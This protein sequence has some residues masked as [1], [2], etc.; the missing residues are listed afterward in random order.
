[1]SA[2]QHGQPGEWAKVRGTVLSLWPLFLSFAALGA[3]AMA[4]VLG[5]VTVLIGARAPMLFGALFL[6][7]LVLTL[8][9]W[10]NGVRSLESFFKGARGEERVASLLASL[11][12]GWHVFHD[13][14]AGPYHVDHVVAGP[15]GVFAVE[16]KNWRGSVVANGGRGDELVVDGH[17]PSRSPTAQ[18][19]AEAEAV[20]AKLAHLGFEVQVVPVVCFASDTLADGI[21][22]IGPVTACN[23]SEVVRWIA[24]AQHVVADDEL[25][26]M[27]Q[28]METAR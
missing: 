16:T 20:K 8:L 24:S 3:F 15:G 2:K 18:A 21:V 19:K 4:F 14:V 25:V 12:D 6:G 22:K 7:S 17:L 5:R 26:R 27:V 10:R 28:L 9:M 23:G 13:F 1:M 11:P